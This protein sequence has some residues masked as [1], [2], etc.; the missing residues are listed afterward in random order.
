LLIVQ[1]LKEVIAFIIILILILDKLIP[2]LMDQIPLNDLIIVLSI[3]LLDLVLMVLWRDVVSNE[4]MQL[5]EINALFLIGRAMSI[6]IF[7]VVVAVRSVAYIAIG[8]ITSSLA[9]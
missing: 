3:T 9:A 1:D 5:F 7:P 2:V 4:S 8:S 6:A